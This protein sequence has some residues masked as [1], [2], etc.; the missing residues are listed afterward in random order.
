M[1]VQSELLDFL[2]ESTDLIATGNFTE[3]YKALERKFPTEADY[4]TP[5]LTRLLE[6][7]EIQPLDFMTD[8][9]SFFYAY[10]QDVKNFTSPSHIKTIGYQAFDH[11][12]QLKTVQLSQGLEG[13]G[14]RAFQSCSQLQ[15][16]AL[17]SSLQ[18]IGKA[19]FAGVMPSINITYAGSKDQLRKIEVHPFLF[20]LNNTIVHCTDGDLKSR[21]F[22]TGISHGLE[23]W[24]YEWKEA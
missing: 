2:R 1:E 17:P 9:P 12:K 22:V 6:G 4:W 14:A 11:C 24:D 18:W 13:I 16:L 7:A 19:A 10:N 3:L 15:E 23:Q 20:N 5:R 8:M 21:R